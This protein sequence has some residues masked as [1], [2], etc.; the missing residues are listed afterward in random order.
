MVDVLLKAE[1]IKTAPR[2]VKAWL[3]A[4][5]EQELNLKPDPSTAPSNVLAECT[6]EEAALVLAGLQSD[7]LACQVFFELGRDRPVENTAATRLHRVAL[8]TV[9]HHVRLDSVEHLATC[10][11]EISRA[12]ANVRRDPEARI[13]ALDNAGYCYVREITRQSIKAVWENLVMS[14]MGKAAEALGARMNVPSGPAVPVD[15]AQAP[16]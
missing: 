7:Y 14:R 4:V 5:L 16:N 15:Q 11:G 13:L 6:I 12:F 8:E 9:M 3:N 2:E 10:L 1:Q